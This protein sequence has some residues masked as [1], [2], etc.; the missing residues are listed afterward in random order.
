LTLKLYTVFHLNLAYSS[1]EEEQ[2]AEVVERCYRPLLNLARELDLPFGIEASAYTLEAAALADPQWFQK[3]RALVS[4]GPCEFIG[5]GYTQLIGPLVPAEVNAANLRLGNVAYERLLGAR[6]EIAL[7][8]EQAY[9]AG[10]VGHYLD[11]GYRAIVME[12]DNPASMHP[13]WPAE[14]RY[15]PQVACGQH[16]E[17][18]PLLWNKSLAF[19]KFQRYAHSEIELDEYLEYLYSHASSTPRAFPLYGGDVEV[20]DFR[21]GRYRTEAELT[22]GVEWERI[23]QLFRTLLGDDRFEFV[24]PSAVLEMLKLPSSG[25]LLHLESAQQPIPVK[26]QGK[27][28]LTRWAVTGRDD[29]AVNTE[30]WRAHEHLCADPASSDADW[31]ELCYLWSSDFRTHITEKRWVAYRARLAAFGRKLDA[32]GS[33]AQPAP[34]AARHHD[35]ETRTITRVDGRFLTIQTDA[36]TLVLNTRRG[37]AIESLT[38][39]G[40]SDRPLVGTLSHGYYDDISLGADFYTGHLVLEPPGAPKVTDLERVEPEVHETAVGLEV[41]GVVATALGPVH[42]TL[43]LV[44]G[45]PVV[46]LSYELDWKGLPAASFRLGYVTLFPDAF[47]RATLYFLCHN[48]GATSERFAFSGSDIDHG[49]PISSLVS[50]TGG[51]GVTGG[52][53]EIGDAVHAVR[54]EVDKA[55]S[56]LIGL[57]TYREVRGSFFCRLAFSAFELDETSRLGEQGH[58]PALARFTIR[59]VHPRREGPDAAGFRTPVPI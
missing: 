57:L 11:A 46:E 18:I 27:Y 31:Q 56:A 13:E 12:W 3:L 32:T 15:L 54:V 55:C 45:E 38:F 33:R 49:R 8:N 28:N 30:C 35:S 58:A 37:L 5:S 9:S 23:G 6:P 40:V 2:R 41:S 39:P 43:R 4:G 59:G 50:A 7:V 1:I 42:K 24:P 10:M 47:D 17:Q 29:L 51:L 25:N 48:G 26:K 22:D 19:Q 52:V 14:W 44:D 34:I 21:P 53:V 36:A 20:F 16:G